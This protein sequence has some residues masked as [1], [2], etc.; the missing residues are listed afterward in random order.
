MKQF[1]FSGNVSSRGKNINYTRML[2]IIEILKQDAK[3]NTIISHNGF[4]AKGYVLIF[5]IFVIISDKT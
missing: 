5:V 2:I 1:S 3:D 4:H